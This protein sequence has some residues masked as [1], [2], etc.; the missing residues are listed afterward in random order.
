MPHQPEVIVIYDTDDDD[1]TSMPH[2]PEPEVIV[3]HD[4]D[5]DD[6]NDDEQQDGISFQ[7][8]DPAAVIE[9]EEPQDSVISVA[10]RVRDD[11]PAPLALTMTMPM[12]TSSRTISFQES[13]PSVAERVRDLVGFLIIVPAVKA[14]NIVETSILP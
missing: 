9:E 12:M 6:A 3:I 11:D 10:E 1:S 13:E 8:D 7:N 4:T 14:C 2:Q 5:D